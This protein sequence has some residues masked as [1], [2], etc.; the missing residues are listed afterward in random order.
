[1]QSAA[2]PHAV[3]VSGLAI[4]CNNAPRCLGESG[5][6]TAIACCTEGDHP[7]PSL[8]S[9]GKALDDAVGLLSFSDPAGQHANPT[10]LFLK[11]SECSLVIDDGRGQASDFFLGFHPR[12]YN[13]GAK[14]TFR[15][16]RQGVVMRFGCCQLS[17]DRRPTC[18]E[19]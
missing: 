2:N 3:R 9:I 12:L 4:N 16:V 5:R 11:I 19:A 14:R 7:R 8:K 6:D 10:R 13:R 18:G 17:S 1:M 15:L